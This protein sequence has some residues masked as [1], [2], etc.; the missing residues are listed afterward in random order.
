MT[1]VVVLASG[2]GSNFE[3]LIRAI[4]SQTLSEVRIE[5]L[6]SDRA[7]AGALDLAKKYGIPAVHVPFPDPGSDLEKRRKLH[8]EMILKALEKFQPRFLVLAGYMRILSRVVLDSF[9]DPKGYCRIVN[10]HPSLLP[11]FPGV[12]SYAQAF[13]YGAKISGVTVHLVEEGVD[14]GPIC[15]QRSFSLES[16]R[17]AREVEARGLEIEHELFPDT[18]NWVLKEN[19]LIEELPQG[20]LRVCKN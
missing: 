2:R 4:E 18:L 3:A 1:R 19:F 5:A 17:S 14:S 13:D 8:G 10:I 9:R 7:Q 11:A 16:F 6:I 15:A 20:R 12:D